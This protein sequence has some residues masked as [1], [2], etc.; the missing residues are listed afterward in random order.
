[1]NVPQ[2]IWSGSFTVFGTE[3]KCHMLEDGTRIIEEDSLIE[4]FNSKTGEA[5]EGDMKKLLAW[6]NGLG[7]F[8]DE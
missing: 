2:A 3:I 1:M 4:F 6:I 8:E 5:D 7:E